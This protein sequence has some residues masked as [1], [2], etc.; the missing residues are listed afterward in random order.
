M[1]VCER[2]GCDNEF[3]LFRVGCSNEKRF[4]CR[5]CKIETFKQTQEYKDAW[6]RRDSERGEYFK[7]WQ[8]KYRK[9]Q[10]Y[11]IRHKDYLKRNPEYVYRTRLRL[12]TRKG[13][14]MMIKTHAKHMMRI[15]G[16]D[17]IETSYSTY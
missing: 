10:K 8:R 7:L 9:T 12:N 3:K 5:S 17:K 13:G 4:C 11:K 2:E 14:E 16:D 1:R 15:L 6:K